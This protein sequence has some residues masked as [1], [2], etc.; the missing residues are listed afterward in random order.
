MGSAIDD[1]NAAQAGEMMLA[2]TVSPYWR[3]GHNACWV[4]M[5]G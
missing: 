2:T 5:Q 1:L 4:A 3:K